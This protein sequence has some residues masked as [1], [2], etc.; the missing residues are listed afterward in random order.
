MRFSAEFSV[1][2]FF[3]DHTDLTLETAMDWSGDANL[4]VRRLASEGSRPRLPWGILLETFVR[5]PSPLIPLLTRLRDDPEDFVRRSV[6]NNL[7]DIAKDHPDLVADLAADWLEGAGA[8][9]RKLVRH[10]CRTLIKDGHAG[11]L[12]AFGYA[13][14]KLRDIRLK[15]PSKVR[16]GGVLDIVFEATSETGQQLHVDYILHFM[17]ANGRL[18]PKVFKWTDVMAKPGE[19]LRLTKAHPYRIVTTRKD[20]PGQ[21]KLSVQINGQVVAEAGF[22]LV[23]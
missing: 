18:S 15:V 8:A 19:K 22:E 12:A 9:R 23:V 16:L 11:A 4:H 14:P 7:N 13:P 17:R 5:D 6:A 21:Q 1:R 10:A 3:R 20:Y 2:P